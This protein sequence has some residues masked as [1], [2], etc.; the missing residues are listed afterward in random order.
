[1]L[2]MNMILVSVPSLATAQPMSLTEQSSPLLSCN[3][4]SCAG[5]I[6]GAVETCF[7]TGTPEEVL[8]C[9]ENILNSIGQGDC[10]A[11]ICDVIPA[12]CQGN[13]IIVTE[14]EV[15]TRPEVDDKDEEEKDPQTTCNLGNF[16]AC[17]G[18]IVGAVET[19]LDNGSADEVMECVRNTI[20]SVGKGECKD[21]ICDIIPQFCQE[22][23]MVPHN[24]VKNDS[25]LSC[26]FLACTS[27]ILG[28]VSTCLDTG[29]PQ[30][31]IECVRNILD[32]I[33]Q[34]DCKDCICDIIP[35]LC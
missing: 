5:S 33:G 6:L 11:C 23:M 24:E 26:N 28:A 22:K 8:T 2:S 10:L 9:V 12:L 27:S 13:N 30:E 3:L 16:A 25:Q 4:L 15:E 19:C 14:D 7:N 1:M 31:V 20:D 29:S 17:A 21:C 34:G 18:S 32:S 35:H